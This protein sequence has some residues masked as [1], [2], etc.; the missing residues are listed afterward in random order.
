MAVM[1]RSIGD[2]IDAVEGV[3]MGFYQRVC[4]ILA[5]EGISGLGQR[6]VHK[7]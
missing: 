3:S 4:L 2:G 6:L 1:V 7:Q 5:R